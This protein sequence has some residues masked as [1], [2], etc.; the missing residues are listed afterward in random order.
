MC[1]RPAWGR[2][3]W[4]G[5]A[6]LHERCHITK[7]AVV[8]NSEH[9][10]AATDVIGD[11]GEF[12]SAIHTAIATCFQKT[13]E[14]RDSRFYRPQCRVESGRPDLRTARLRQGEKT[15]YRYPAKLKASPHT[16][17]TMAAIDGQ[18]LSRPIIGRI[19]LA[20]DDAVPTLM[21]KPV[22]LTNKNRPT[23]LVPRTVCRNVHLLFMKQ[24]LITAT[25]NEIA[26]KMLYTNPDRPL[27]LIAIRAFNTARS[28]L[29]LI[30]PTITNRTT[31]ETKS[32]S[33]SL[34][35]A[36]LPPSGDEFPLHS[37]E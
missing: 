22:T 12:P 17:P 7:S 25:R 4:I 18:Y 33:L 10:D 24:L 31:W 14:A 34:P 16:A 36:T 3:V 9:G 5:F 2:L 23:C 37:H 29:V 28:T 6:V 27:W 11:H 15:K 35:L 19:K 20:M 13:T 26:L 8:Q 21:T 30:I 1:A 32:S